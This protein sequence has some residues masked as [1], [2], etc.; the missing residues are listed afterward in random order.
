MCPAQ[1]SSTKVLEDEV[2]AFVAL[3]PQLFYVAFRILGNTTESEDVLQDTW[4]R[5][6]NTD[7][8]RVL[9]PP[10][11]LARTTARLALNVAQSARSRHETG[12]APWAAET[13]D[14]TT[15]PVTR[16]ERAEALESALH[17]LLAKLNPTERAAYVLRV[18][19]GY[20][21][22]QI[23]DNL[24]LSG[25]NT[26][27]IVSRARKRLCTERGKPVSSVEHQRLVDAFVAAAQ[28][29]NFTDLENILTVD[30][31][32]N[33]IHTDRFR[34]QATERSTRI[35]QHAAAR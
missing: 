33:R 7:R 20:P 16:V 28:S 18:A 6:Q 12:A 3:R 35:R 21:Y 2:T 14:T 23:A 22:S 13:I 19:F 5:W 24:Q 17:L 29:G 9:D 31:D 26:R 27:Q 32:R 15:D 8:A 11:F 10:A 25:V 1:I 34:V 30:A 4:L